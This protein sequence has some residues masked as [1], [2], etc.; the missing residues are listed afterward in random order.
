M[1][2]LLI[3]LELFSHYFGNIFSF[4]KCLKMP[5]FSI[6]YYVT[7]NAIKNI[8]IKYTLTLTNIKC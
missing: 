2:D 8:I 6:V 7:L 3:Q 4:G 5:K 1:Y